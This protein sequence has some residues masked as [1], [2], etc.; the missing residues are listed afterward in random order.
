MI[1]LLQRVAEAAVTV[2]ATGSAGTETIGRIGPGCLALV[3][4]QRGDGEAQARRLLQRILA[5]RMFDDEQGRMNRDLRQ[6]K[7]GLLL[8]PQFTLAAD[9][10]SGNRPSFTP[11]APPEVGKQ[12]FDWLVSSA[13]QQWS[14]VETGRFGADMRVHL[15]NQGPV[16]F[17]LQVDPGSV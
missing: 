3:G 2:E 5:W 17:W 6:V 16:T 8:V 1:A 13:R 10:D 7:G 4:V 15:V 14:Q 12:W 9:T 11:A